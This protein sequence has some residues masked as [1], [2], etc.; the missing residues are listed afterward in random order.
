[1]KGLCEHYRL[2]WSP[3][4]P[5]EV[6]R[7]TQ[8]FRKGKGRK[9]GK[10][11]MGWIRSDPFSPVFK[12]VSV[13]RIT[14]SIGRDPIVK[15]LC[16][17][18]NVDTRC[19]N[20][21]KRNLWE[22]LCATRRSYATVCLNS[23]FHFKSSV[24]GFEP[25]DRA[26]SNIEH[27]T[28]PSHLTWNFILLTFILFICL[29]KIYTIYNK[30]CLCVVRA[31]SCGLLFKKFWRLLTLVCCQAEHWQRGY[32]DKRQIAPQG[33]MCTRDILPAMRLLYETKLVLL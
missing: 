9:K 2:K 20:K 21:S 17:N 30:N 11:G 8:Y 25:S 18:Q 23:V 12:P 14:H 5:N 19:I 15:K 27:F 6:C 10:D 28:P 3:F 32:P 1:M 13:S 26:C 33:T 7:I 31:G 29:L 16:C 24:M 22:I 4:P